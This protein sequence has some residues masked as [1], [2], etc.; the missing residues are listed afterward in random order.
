MVLFAHLNLILFLLRSIDFAMI[1]KFSHHSTS[2]SNDKTIFGLVDV[3]VNFLA[4]NCSQLIGSLD[5]K[6]QFKPRMDLTQGQDYY[7]VDR[8]CTFCNIII[9]L[10]AVLLQW[11]WK[12][13]AFD[14]KI[15][16]LK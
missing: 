11:Q 13:S 8:K 3:F 7:F 16:P 12:K 15:A 6:L 2:Q 1:T 4:R 5:S 10:I 14:S 9:G